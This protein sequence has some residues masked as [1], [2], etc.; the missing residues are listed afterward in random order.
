MHCPK[1]SAKI[2]NLARKCKKMLDI[3]TSTSTA[4]KGISYDKVT[5]KSGQKHRGS[6]EGWLWKTDIN[7]CSLFSVIQSSAMAI[8]I[9]NFHR[10]IANLCCASTI[11]ILTQ[12]TILFF[13]WFG[14]TNANE[15]STAKFTAVLNKS[16]SQIRRG[17]LSTND[18]RMSDAIVIDRGRLTTVR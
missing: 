2:G 7:Y 15:F 1:N 17:V 16:V 11:V 18:C 9:G 12:S 14:R 13:S 8:I 4:D 5:R 3:T 6:W 10:T